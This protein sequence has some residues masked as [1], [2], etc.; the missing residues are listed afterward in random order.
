[1]FCH[2]KIIKRVDPSIKL[3]LCQSIQ[4]AT[5]NIIA[6]EKENKCKIIYFDEKKSNPDNNII[7]YGV[8]LFTLFTLFTFLQFIFRKKNMCVI[9]D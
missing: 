7:L 1:M 8:S 3:Y 5:Q 2:T 9:Y 6:R 4:R